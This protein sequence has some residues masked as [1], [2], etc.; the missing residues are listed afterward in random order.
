MNPYG[1]PPTQFQAA[2]NRAQAVTRDLARKAGPKMF[3]TAATPPARP[4]RE[5]LG[6]APDGP[7]NPNVREAA[8]GGQR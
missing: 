4:R 7:I 5:S 6:L 1:K 8:I 2:I 3:G